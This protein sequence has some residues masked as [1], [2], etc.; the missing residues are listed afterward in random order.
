MASLFSW[1]SGDVVMM[2]N[3]QKRRQFSQLQERTLPT[4]GSH[5]G[6]SSEPRGFHSVTLTELKPVGSDND[7]RKVQRKTTLA[8]LQ[9]NAP[10]H[11]AQ[12]AVA[13]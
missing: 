7:L 8:L 5:L 13:A 1:D 12:F 9:D 3:L 6:T 10:V 4:E 2:D 11:K